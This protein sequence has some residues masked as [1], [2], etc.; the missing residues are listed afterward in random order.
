MS[1]TIG[2]SWFNVRFGGVDEL[3]VRCREGARFGYRQAGRMSGAWAPGVTFLR[4]K[5]V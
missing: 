1:L 5:K 4:I 3:T 2:R